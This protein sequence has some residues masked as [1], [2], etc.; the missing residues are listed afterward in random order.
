VAGEQTRAAIEAQPQA[1]RTV[2]SDARLPAGRTLH[3][4]CG[5]SFHAAQ[6]GGEAVQALEL[7][8][9]PRRD[10]DVLVCVS[11]A[12]TTPITLE[13]AR[14]WDG[15]V[16]V[17]T[18]NPDGAIAA[19]ADEVVLTPGPVEE[20]WCH[21]RSYTTAVATL[22]ALRGEDV[23]WLPDAVEAALAVRE[24]ASAHERWLVAGAGRDWP[25]ALEP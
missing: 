20:S 10:A 3:T 19:E 22:A 8:L 5:T 17:V 9:Q 25:T 12:G 4:G 1:L 16:W 21:T 13:A 24:P 23:A 14:A 7:V 15:P 11:H 2:R 6:T 18:A